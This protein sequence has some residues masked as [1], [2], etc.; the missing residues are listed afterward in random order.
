MAQALLSLGSNI[1]PEANLRAAAADLRAA[2][3][4]AHRCGQRCRPARS[5]PALEGAAGRTANALVAQASGEG[6]VSREF[7]GLA[8]FASV[9]TI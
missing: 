1:D 7:Q 3:P 8:G 9:L 4:G 2:F 5:L 6:K